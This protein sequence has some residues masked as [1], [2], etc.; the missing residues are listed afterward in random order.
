MWLPILLGTSIS[1]YLGNHSVGSTREDSPDLSYVWVL[2]S[3]P[4]SDNTFGL[5]IPICSHCSAFRS[6]ILPIYMF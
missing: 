5:F 1:D 6:G 3:V 4:A 2:G